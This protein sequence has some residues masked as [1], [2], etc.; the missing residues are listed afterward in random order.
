MLDMENKG[1]P[2]WGK[3]SAKLTDEGLMGSRRIDTNESVYIMQ[4]LSLYI[5][6]PFCVKKCAYC[7]FL[8][9]PADEDTREKYVQ[10]LIREIRSYENSDDARR[11]VR[12]IFIGGGTPSVL[13]TVQIG[14]V[15]GAVKEAFAGLHNSDCDI[16]SAVKNDE[17]TTEITME[18]NPGTVMPEECRELCK[19]GINRFSIGLQSTDNGELQRLGRIHTYE[20]FLQTYHALR[21]AGARNI[22]IDLMAALPGQTLEN[23][24]NSLHKVAALNP[25]HISAYSLILEEGTPLYERYHEAVDITMDDVSDLKWQLPD[26]DTERKMYETTAE[27]LREYGYQRYEISNYAKPG[28]ECRHNQVYWQR[29]DYLGFGIGAASCIDNVRW[30]NIDGLHN[31]IDETF[32]FSPVESISRNED[33]KKQQTEGLWH[34]FKNGIR[35]DIRPLS[36][37]EQMEETMFLGLRQTMGISISAF[38]KS[39]GKSLTDVYGDVIDKYK[40]MGML[41]I[42]GDRLFLTPEGMIVSNPILADF[43]L[44][45]VRCGK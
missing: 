19:L 12:S 29:E 45:N 43:L 13:H 20:E 6:I 33:R 40:Q 26:E 9:A 14:R 24:M 3:L 16:L 21:D 18:L 2:L 10:A 1:F 42:E 23:Y 34:A 36:I 28:Y 7:D 39:F 35:E 27:V 30:K 41:G 17:C 25:E 37:E 11:P 32:T 31:Y 8:S 5:H 22:N 44:E 15:L 38:E 4:P